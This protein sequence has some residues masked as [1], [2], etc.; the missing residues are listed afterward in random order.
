MTMK[1]A[2]AKQVPAGAQ[3]AAVPDTKP[4]RVNMQSEFVRMSESSNLSMFGVITDDQLS[5]LLAPGY[6]HQA[7]DALVKFD[8]IMFTTAAN[9]PGPVHGTLIVTGADKAT[10]GAGVTVSVLSRSDRT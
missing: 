10:R 9:S 2:T 7:R 6:F 8:R 5:D 1:T 3:P 4:P